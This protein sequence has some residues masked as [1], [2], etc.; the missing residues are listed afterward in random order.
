MST[1]LEL[2]KP[3]VADA[4]D[5][6]ARTLPDYEYAALDAWASTFYPFQRDWLFDMSEFAICNK[7]RRIG[8]SHSSAAM[9]VLW[10]AFHGE[11]TTI[12]SKGQR[13]SKEVLRVAKKHAAILRA[14]GSEM[15]CLG[16]IDNAEELSFASGGRILALP[17]SSGGRGYDGNILLD[18][19]AYA[20]HAASVWD[21]AAAVSLLGNS[22]VRVI[23]TPNGVG[24]EFAELWE[25]SDPENPNRDAEAIGSEYKWNRYSISIEEAIAQGY[26]VDI[27]KC[28]ATAKGDPRLF[29]QLF[30]CSF[31][32]A[33]LQ[34]LP[35]DEVDACR[36]HELDGPFTSYYGGLDIGR[37]NDLTVLTVVG[38]NQRR[39]KVVH[40][41]ARRR[42]SMDD[43]IEIVGNAFEKYHLTRLSID[44]TGLG[45]FPCDV[46]VQKFGEK[47]VP[48]NKRPRVEPIAFTQK[49]K[50]EIATGLY[51][52]IA[53]RTVSLPRNDTL[54]GGGDPGVAAK[55]R[56]D[57][58]SIQRIVTQ[59]GNVVYDA[60][61]TKTGHADYAWSLGLA[62][63]A[64]GQQNP[65]LEAL[66]R[67]MMGSKQAA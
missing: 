67:R 64:T 36:T 26:P 41:A 29:N 51:G 25:T 28:W 21:S 38:Y 15:A 11:A 60:P 55:L 65:M 43:I 13:E 34:Y 32:D 8:L 16:D 14:L 1:L 10:G 56:K 50:E 19:Y 3:H 57:L 31:L 35:T 66:R 63:H 52:A 33:V 17:A 59:A 46:L 24:N 45:I 27:R 49:S 39:R 53:G 30:N 23:S 42:T 7:S 47:H 4:L 20:Q 2:D 44:E 5:T 37:E 40:T 48:K 62:L 6:Y 22:R 58:L 61:R 54:P 12:I 9:G 18:E